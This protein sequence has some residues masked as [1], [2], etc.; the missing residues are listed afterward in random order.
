MA[1]RKI[2]FRRFVEGDTFS[3]GE[4]DTRFA[5]L[6]RDLNNTKDG[7][8]AVT[9]AEGA[10][11]YHHL[12]N[13]GNASTTGFNFGSTIVEAKSV[14]NTP[15]NHPDA[16]QRY[17]PK[18]QPEL[19]TRG[20]S[21]GWSLETGGIIGDSVYFSSP[22][23]TPKKMEVTLSSLKMGTDY[24]TSNDPSYTTGLVLMFDTYVLRSYS[25]SGIGIEL[26]IQ[27]G[28]IDGSTFYEWVPIKGCSRWV[29][30]KWGGTDVSPSSGQPVCIR[31]FLD[32][33]RIL[34][35]VGSLN[36]AATEANLTVTGI[37]AKIGVIG[38][39]KSYG[40]DQIF[41]YLRESSL[42]VLALRAKKTS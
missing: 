2:N 25:E 21:E 32:R 38:E 7:L 6:E 19:R 5:Q 36:P 34:E 20:R 42:S 14:R 16:W 39:N 29:W 22:E 23:F 33:A 8:H 9:I 27:T 1:T 11:D 26:Q 10:V 18:A 30:D 17:N 3:T 28:P 13:P 12:Q 31:A 4:I 15:S 24:Y 35:S 37:R 41:T 40:S